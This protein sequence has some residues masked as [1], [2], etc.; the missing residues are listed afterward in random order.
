MN[1]QRLDIILG[2][3]EPSRIQVLDLAKQLSLA[4]EEVFHV[5]DKN[6]FAHLSLYF[7]EI[8]VEDIPALLRALEE[9]A[10]EFNRF[11]VRVSQIYAV[12]GSIALDLEKNE[13]L[14][15]IEAMVVKNLNKFRQGKIRDKYLERIKEG[16]Y[17]PQQT[18]LIEEYGCPDILELYAPH[19]TLGRLVSPEL[20]ERIAKE[21]NL[22][23]EI[24]IISL[25]VSEMGAHGTCIN[26]IN[27]FNLS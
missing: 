15:K 16:Y 1:H 25:A 24:E 23:K 3:A 11:K 6:Y 17:S 14:E 20:A 12:E 8:A 13:V 19:I 27:K 2:L 22:P 21:L 7:L 4:G 18:K 26:I 10:G 9:M 5:D